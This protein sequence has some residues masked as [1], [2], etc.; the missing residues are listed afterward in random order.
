VCSGGGA[1]G[2]QGAASSLSAGGG[3]GGRERQRGRGHRGGAAVHQVCREGRSL[4]EQMNFNSFSS[5]RAAELPPEPPPAS[6]PRRRRPPAGAAADHPPAPPLSAA[7]DCVDSSDRVR[8]WRPSGFSLQAF[9][10]SARDLGFSTCTSG[11]PSRQGGS[12]IYDV[13]PTQLKMGM[14]KKMR[15]EMTF[16]FAQ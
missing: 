14:R 13:Q 4:H 10:R 5:V 2:Q 3:I 12:T 8:E 16:H 11:R 7:G 6:R 15:V 1:W 9:R